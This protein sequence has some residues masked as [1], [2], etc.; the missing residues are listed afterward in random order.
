MCS[1]H[2]ILWLHVLLTAGIMSNRQSAPVYLDFSCLNV[3]YLNGTLICFG[4]ETLDFCLKLYVG[5]KPK[6]PRMK[7][8]TFVGARD[9]DMGVLFPTNDRG[10]S[11]INEEMFDSLTEL[12][13]LLRGQVSAI[14]TILKAVPSL[15][16]L[17]LYQCLTEVKYALSRVQTEA[18]ELASL[19]R[20]P[21]NS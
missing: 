14:D 7:S 11:D 21:I 9:H 12:P 17:P 5:R 4:L 13:E 18:G 20:A 16:H 19:S 3:P 8:Q 2:C 15:N 1:R 6:E 10:H